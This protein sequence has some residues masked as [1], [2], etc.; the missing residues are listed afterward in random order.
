MEAGTRRAKPLPVQAPL[1][2]VDDDDNHSHVVSQ[3]AEAR[4]F[5]AIDRY[6]CAGLAI[7]SEQASKLVVAFGLLSSSMSQR[8][9]NQGPLERFCFQK[10]FN[11]SPTNSVTG[12]PRHQDYYKYHD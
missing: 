9:A 8:S 1:V 3:E 2:T 11:F 5:T 10:I 7:T 12:N 6:K 4:L